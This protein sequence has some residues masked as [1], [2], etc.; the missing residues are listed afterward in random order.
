MLPC[1]VQLFIRHMK[2]HNRLY[3]AHKSCVNRV[4]LCV[5]RAFARDYLLVY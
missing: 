3:A 1:H 2:P 5:L 4:L